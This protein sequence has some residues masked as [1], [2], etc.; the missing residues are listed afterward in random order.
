MS[1]LQEENIYFPEE[2]KKMPAAVGTLVASSKR[3]VFA[4]VLRVVQPHVLPRVARIELTHGSVSS[5]C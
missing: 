3:A 4:V 1:V 2:H 5:N